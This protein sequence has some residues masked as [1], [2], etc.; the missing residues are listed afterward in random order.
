MST[1]RTKTLVLGDSGTLAN[2]LQWKVPGVPDGTL[3]LERE[4]GTDVLTIDANGNVTVA[5][6]GKF[7]KADFSA[8]AENDKVAFQTS[9]TNGNTVINAVPNGT[10]QVSTFRAWS[11]SD[12]TNASFLELLSSTTDSRIGSERSG[13]GTYLPFTFYSGGLERARFTTNGDFWINNTADGAP[14]AAGSTNTGTAFER[15]VDGTTLFLSRS[16]FPE[17]YLNRNSDG[18]VALF[19]R[20]GFN[21]GGVSVTTTTTTYLTSSDYRLK[22]GIAPIYNSLNRLMQLKP[23][24]F[25]W[26]PDGSYDESFI[27]HELQEVCPRAV[28]GKKDAVKEDGTP[29]Y[30]QI[31]P[32]KIVALLTAAMQEQQHIIEDLR[33]RIQVLE[34]SK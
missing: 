26:K 9:V 21:V 7:F 28:T 34:A 6:T 19:N 10:A 20:S 31:D 33:L 8:A 23:C 30:Q 1:V 17:L 14:G 22:E 32:S 11:A 13:A 5:G 3:T 27:A 16:A 24:G 18:L 29:D 15:A 4:N 25:T 2:N 12:R